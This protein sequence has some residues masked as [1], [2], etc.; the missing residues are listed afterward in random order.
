[1][2]SMLEW[3]IWSYQKFLQLWLFPWRQDR[4]TQ[5]ENK[6]MLI[7]NGDRAAQTIND[8]VIG[9]S[10]RMLILLLL[11]TCGSCSHCCHYLQYMWSSNFRQWVPDSLLENSDSHLENTKPRT[12]SLVEAHTYIFSF[13]ITK[14]INHDIQGFMCRMMWSPLYQIDGNEIEFSC[15]STSETREST[16]VCTRE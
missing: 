3:Q 12:S 15:S 1:M 10:T 13:T 2:Q 16:P 8:K 9:S 4:S 7:R 14:H 6:D 11:L 5:Q